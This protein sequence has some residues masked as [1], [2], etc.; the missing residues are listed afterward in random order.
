VTSKWLIP[1]LGFVLVTGMLGVT[2]K[3]A[4]RDVEWPV[5]LLWSAIVYVVIGL[6]VVVFG[7]ASLHLDEA[8]GRWA[9]VAGVC[10]AGGLTCSLI[11]LR[12]A[13][14]VVATPVMAVYPA[15]TVIGSLAFLGESFGPVKA[16]GLGLV[17]GGV[18]LLAR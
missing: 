13:D 11:A 2:V 16:V 6:G 10:A 17:I 1:A 3:L 8:G 18:I 9:L 15:V 12:H 7:D 14:A 4:L 5:I